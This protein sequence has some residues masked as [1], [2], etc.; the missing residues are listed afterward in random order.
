MDGRV[1]PRLV[2]ATDRKFH[3]PAAVSK[4]G[5]MDDDSDPVSAPVGAGTVVVFAGTAL[6]LVTVTWHVREVFAIGRVAGPGLALVLDGLPAVG[7]IYLGRRLNRSGLPAGVRWTV[8]RWGATGS[9]VVGG[10]VA[11]TFVVRLLEGRAVV[12]PVFPLLAAVNV[13]GVVGLV[14]GLRDARARVESRR[15]ESVREALAFV[16]GL[17]RHDLINDLVAI[18]STTTLLADRLDDDEHVEVIATKTDEALERLE[19]TRDVA[20]TL[21]GDDPPGTIDLTG[22]VRSAV[23]SLDGSLDATVEVDLPERAVVVGNDGLRSV[24]DNLLENAV[25]HTDEVDPTVRVSVE[26]DDDRCRLRVADDGPGLPEDLRRWFEGADV[27]GPDGGLFI[28]RRLVAEYGGHVRVRDRDPRGTVFVV[29]LDRPDET[30][31]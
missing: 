14:A 5:R 7:V 21:V 10:I 27:E 23:E 15:A 19:T 1:T 17:V 3:A 18:R 30:V 28:V 2:A 24:V 13:G 8:V 9:V 6:A 31:P 11:L 25:Q 22:V 4:I 26:C 12:E 20:E 16:N 29:T